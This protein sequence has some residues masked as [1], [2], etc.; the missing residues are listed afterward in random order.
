MPRMDGYMFMHAVQAHPETSHIPVILMSSKV[1]TEEEHQALRAGFV[2]FVGKPAMPIRVIVSVK[3]ALAFQ[4]GAPR[5]APKE[6]ERVSP[7][8]RRIPP[9][10]E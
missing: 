6:G 4:E 2:D 5:P 7:R 10:K 8:S 9:G 3:R 1:S